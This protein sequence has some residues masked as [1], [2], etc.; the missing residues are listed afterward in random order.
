MNMNK[1]VIMVVRDWRWQRDEKEQ[2]AIHDANTQITDNLMAQYPNTL[3]DTCGESVWLPEGY[4]GNSEVWHMT[5]GSWRILFQSFV[6]INKSIEDGEF[7]TIP[8]F[9]KAIDNCKE[10]NSKL[11]LIGLI[12]TQGVHAHLDHLYALLELCKRQDFKDV[13]IHAI[14]D[15]RDAPSMEW[16]KNLKDLETKIQE[17]GVGEIATVSWRFFTM[18]RDNR[19]E[20]TQRGYE[21]IVDAK[22][23][24]DEKADVPV[25]FD[26]VDA[27]VQACYD[28]QETDEFIAPRIKKWY[29]GMQDKDS[30]IFFN[31]RTDRT[32]QLT[33]AIVEDTFDGFERK[34]KDI[35]YVAMTQFY[36][37]MPAD[38]AFKEQSLDNLLGEVVA[39]EW[40]KQL[41]ISETEKYAH[42]TFFF[43]GQDEKPNDNEDRILIPSP[44]VETYDL[45]PEMS[46]Y[47]ITEELTKKIESELY[48]L[49]ITNL[50][51]GDMVGHTG[52]P[53]AIKK[54][55][56]AVDACVWKIV[57][58]GLEHNYTTIITAD[59]GNAED[60]TD[61]RRTSHTMNKVPCIIVSDDKELKLK[62]GK[63]L[64]D[65]APTVLDLMGIEKPEEM[66]GE[67]IIES[68]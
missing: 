59:H 48:D 4:Q 29:E 66:T 36:E 13:Y 40:R 17:I 51:N 52:N 35:H 42:V 38:V 54:A 43:N 9:L 30:A 68:K 32:R 34:K 28:Q 60:Q 5:I 58:K 23:S 21:A 10:N 53:E 18:D 61:E 26:S 22:V 49:I 12:Q 47:E 46:V 6:K 65:L 16:L 7:F 24:P 44:R 57:E 11:H 37:G 19:R 39:K 56:E 50:V 33:K 15:G 8:E 2:N 41:R 14:T 25:E 1:K 31:F 63:W 55:L 3:L 27:M 62:E 64:Q 67:S 45:K 20:R